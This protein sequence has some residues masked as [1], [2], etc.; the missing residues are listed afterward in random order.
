MSNIFN[1]V[2]A[3]KVPRSTFNLSYEKKFTADMGILYPVM[4]DEV[5]PGDIVKIGNQSV[6][7]ANPMVAP[8]MHEIY[9]TTHY[10]HV[11]Y[12]ILDED[13]PEFI[14]GGEDG[15]SSITLPR[16]DPIGVDENALGSLWDYFGFPVGINPTGA[17]PLDYPKR[18]Y[19]LTWNEYFRDQNTMTELDITTNFSL[20]RASWTKDRFTSALPFQQRGTA[21]AL[22]ITGTTKAIWENAD[23][24]QVAPSFQ[25]GFNGAP[26]NAVM[27][28]NNATA[29]ANAVNF[30]NAN[31]VDLSGASTFDVN[32]LRLAFQLQKWLE[33]NARC[34]SRY[35]EFL[36]AHF[37]VA[38][39][40]ER[41]NR[42][43]YIGGCKSNITISEVLQT[44]ETG[45]SP[46]G[47]LAGHGI[48]VDQKYI[49]KYRVKE[50]GLI[51]GLMCIR[52]RPA[53]SQ[54]I[55]KQWLR[56]VKED[57]Y[58][59]EF[60]HLSEQAITQAEIYATGVQTENET[61]F[62]YQGIYNEMRTKQNQVCGLLRPGQSLDYWTLGRE[63]SAAPAL[64]QAFIECNPSKR[65]FAV[66]SEP[67][68]IVTIGNIIKA[69]RPMPY[70]AEPGLIDHF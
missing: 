64:N 6:V 32:D 37:N 7:R 52:P 69:F 15:Q 31:D 36:Q 59:P 11:P 27:Q 55:D 3:V 1:T 68:F 4:C 13:F 28:I 62:G 56:T 49:G 9:M 34:G 24:Q 51:I 26:G 48:G 46:Q 20:Q 38:P 17:L 10:F 19:N 29:I 67:G 39:R 8:P 54:G 23:F 44:S 65:I 66:T 42:P 58:F 50:F 53:Y 43:E 18:A 2:G 16:W 63:F 40:D 41:L 21:P 47:N 22:P 35:T 14:T 61:I 25:G 70:L 57:F 60:S 5:V 12:R 33:R 30:F 45:T